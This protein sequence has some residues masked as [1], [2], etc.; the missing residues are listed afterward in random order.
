MR[1]SAEP[2]GDKE[3]R[4]GPLDGGF[5]YFRYRLPYMGGHDPKRRDFEHGR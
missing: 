3:Y 2:L 4:A 5:V 1:K